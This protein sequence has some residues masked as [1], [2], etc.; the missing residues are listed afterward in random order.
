MVRRIKKKNLNKEISNEDL[1][2]IYSEIIIFFKIATTYINVRNVYNH[3]SSFEIITFKTED[4]FELS[5][6]VR[7]SFYDYVQFKKEENN[8]NLKNVIGN[9][10]VDGILYGLEIE[11]FINEL[12]KLEVDYSRL[13][14]ILNTFE[15][16]SPILIGEIKSGLVKEKINYIKLVK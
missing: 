6:Y 2:L 1:D 15:P 3:F 9:I 16:M 13:R 7:E 4:L 14:T 10:L 8:E 5:K 12:K 11:F